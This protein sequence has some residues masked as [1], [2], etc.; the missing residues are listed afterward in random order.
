MLGSKGRCM[1]NTYLHGGSAQA[2]G[3][4]WLPIL[5]G[6]VCEALFQAGRHVNPLK[7]FQSLQQ[8][9][10]ADSHRLHR[11][12]GAI[13]SLELRCMQASAGCTLK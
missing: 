1:M 8:C 5:E 11:H 13:L 10:S 7:V 4:F 9:R 2:Q 6:E 3:L 12:E